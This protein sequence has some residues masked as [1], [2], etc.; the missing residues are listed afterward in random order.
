MKYRNTGSTPL[1]VDGKSV[2]PG[3]L[4]DG[5]DVHPGQLMRWSERIARVQ[6]LAK[7]SKEAPAETPAEEGN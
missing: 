1:I 6:S 5:N 4:F 7:P 2:E 3:D